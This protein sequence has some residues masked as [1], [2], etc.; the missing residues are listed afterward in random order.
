MLTAVATG[1]TDRLAAHAT[2]RQ[3]LVAGLL[4]RITLPAGQRSADPASRKLSHMSTNRLPKPYVT[5]HCTPVAAR[6]RIPDH[7]R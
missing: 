5:G 3:A 1:R 4:A 2:A 7:Q 6:H